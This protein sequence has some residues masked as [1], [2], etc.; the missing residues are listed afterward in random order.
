MQVK[1]N[2]SGVVARYRN[3]FKATA[4]AFDNANQEAL[5]Q[6]TYWAGFEN[7]TTYRQSGEVVTGAYRN[8]ADLGNLA[9]SQTMNIRGIGSVV[10]EWDGNGN[11]PAQ[12]VYFG[13]RLNNGGI[14]PAR[15]W[16]DRALTLVDLP[17][18]FSDNFN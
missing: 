7:S 5:T 3:A 12:I 13:A 11:T 14:I 9:D 10:Y 2:K 8:I 1:S 18:I 6:S 17:T 16:S 15:R 4:I